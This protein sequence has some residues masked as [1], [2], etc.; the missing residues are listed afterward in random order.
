M[1]HQLGSFPCQ[2]CMIGGAIKPNAI[3]GD[4]TRDTSS[5]KVRSSGM[6]LVSANE[7]VGSSARLLTQ[8][9]LDSS[10]AACVDPATK[11]IW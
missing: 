2:S 9:R 5:S 6:T 10:E 3:A 8:P 7:S 4:L 11:S 1:L